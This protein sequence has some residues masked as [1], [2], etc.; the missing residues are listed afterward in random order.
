[1]LQRST[2]ALAGLALASGIA[3]HRA[4]AETGAAG[5][6]GGAARGKRWFKIGACDWSLERSDA[7]SFSVA[8][9][10]GLDGVQVSLGSAGNGMHL[11]R[12]DVQE[13][14]RQAARA[15][16]LEFA[17]LA[18]GELNNV[19]LATEPKAA[20]WLV[21][22]ID[23]ARDLGM[24]V[25]LMAFFGRGEVR[26]DDTVNM[27]R[28][29]DLLKEVTPRAE[30]AGVVLGLENY[31]SAEDNVK[32]LDRVGSPALQVY[33]DVGNSTDKGYDILREIRFLGKDRICEFHA[34]D[35]QHLFGKGRIDFREVRKAMDDIGYTGWIQIEGAKPN[36][37]VV[38]Y[39]ADLAYL[40]SIFPREA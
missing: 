32:I 16:G 21:D 27:G 23:V 2:R 38:D 33:Y 28:L 5:G 10:I 40:R 30:K 6:S 1:M 12:K 13:A 15:T 22:G 25:I 35:A 8:K 17:S 34:K 14:Y 11:R 26:P 7:S 9:E 18:L 39:Q 29:V 4:A 3:T 24:K 36:G 19:P 31:L 20:V 37:V